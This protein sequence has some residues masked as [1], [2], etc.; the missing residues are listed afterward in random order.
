MNITHAVGNV[1][2]FRIAYEAAKRGYVVSIPMGHDVK[3][4]LIVDRGGKL[5][6]VQVKTVTSNGAVIKAHM[7]SPG[8]IDGK[9][10][11]NKYT[12][13]DVDWIVVFDVTTE[14]CLFVPASELGSSGKDALTFRVKPA[15]NNQRK[16]VRF[17][18]DYMMW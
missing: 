10:S 6:R 1:G 5:E 14:L 8:R 7:R 2:E 13:E 15:K 16:N 17:V 3:Y 11:I 9:I 12:S 18:E 4:D